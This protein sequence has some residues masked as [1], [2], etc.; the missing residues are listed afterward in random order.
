MNAIK[1]LAEIAETVTI[2]RSGPRRID[3]RRGERGAYRLG[4]SLE[5]LCRRGRARCDDREQLCRRRSE[6][7]GWR[8][9]PGSDL[10]KRGITQRAL[11]A[12]AIPAGYLSEIGRRGKPGSVTAYRALALAVPIEEFVGDE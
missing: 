1:P 7:P 8:R 6:E 11:A 3:R 5:C 4:S 2:G 9:G 12:A 10:E